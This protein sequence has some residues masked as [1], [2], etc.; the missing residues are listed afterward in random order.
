MG[1]DTI[2]TGKII[3]SINNV[4]ICHRLPDRTFNFKGHYFPVCA[5]CTGFYMGAFSYYIYAYFFYVDYSYYIVFLGLLLLIPSLLDGSTQ[6]LNLRLSNN[7]LRFFTGLLGGMGLG[8]LIKAFKWAII[9]Q[10]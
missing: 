4:P 5:R 2:Y 3:R 7:S 8:I 9:I 1:S 6:L 10:L